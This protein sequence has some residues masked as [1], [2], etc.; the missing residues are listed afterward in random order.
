MSFHGFNGR[1][2]YDPAY[3]PD[4]EEIEAIRELVDDLSLVKVTANLEIEDGE[5]AVLFNA[6]KGGG[7]ESERCIML[8]SNGAK[9]FMTPNKEVPR[10]KQGLEES[11]KKWRVGGT[12]DNQIR[13]RSNLWQ[14]VYRLSNNKDKANYTIKPKQEL[15][16]IV[17]E[18][19]LGN[20]TV[21]WEVEYHNRLVSLV[22]DH[23]GVDEDDV[24]EQMISD[25]IVVALH[26]A[27]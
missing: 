14:Q 10:S 12:E 13:R 2:S 20:G 26:E 21:Q 8:I 25:F 27:I 15:I 11:F 6:I 16:D 22:A 7:T 17:E 24:G 9:Y 4:D 23:Y 18:T 5:Q 1:F 3:H 19:E